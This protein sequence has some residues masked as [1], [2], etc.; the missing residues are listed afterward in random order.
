MWS[1]VMYD[2]HMELRLGLRWCGKVRVCFSSPEIKLAY[3][4]C[5][6]LPR[7]QKKKLNPPYSD[8]SNQPAACIHLMADCRWLLASQE[9]QS[10]FDSGRLKKV[11]LT[12]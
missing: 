7:N 9:A 11:G 3:Q 1:D 2:R 4:R 12:A 6:K 5:H 10:K 8:L